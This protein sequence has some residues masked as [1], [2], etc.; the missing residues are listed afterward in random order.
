MI[1]GIDKKRGGD[2]TSPRSGFTLIELLVVIAVIGIMAAMLLPALARARE[3]ARR[4][5]C[6]SRLSQLGMALQMY[7]EENNRM[8]PWSG[9]NNNAEC[10]MTLYSNYALEKK[11]F[12]CPSDAQQHPDDFEEGSGFELNTD[13]EKGASLRSSY[14]YLG[15]FTTA[16]ILLPHPSLGSS[17]I[18]VFWDRSTAEPAYFNHIPGGSNVLF[19]D[20]SVEFLKYPDFAEPCLPVRPEG[21]AFMN[22]QEVIDQEIAKQREAG[23][24]GARG[25]PG[26]KKVLGIKKRQARSLLPKAIAR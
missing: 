15:A 16:P 2:T 4:S 26:G 5:S 9:G 19:T 1:Q 3:A 14:E 8:L 12:L 17:K 13:I 18:P 23:K 11:L 25:S 20:G 7:A 10:L 21:I 6:M 24:A 22:I